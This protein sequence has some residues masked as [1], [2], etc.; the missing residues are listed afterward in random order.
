MAWGAKDAST[1]SVEL[2]TNSTRSLSVRGLTNRD[3][4]RERN[5]SF[6]ALP[7]EPN[8]VVRVISSQTHA[9]M[10]NIENTITPKIEPESPN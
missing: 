1:T 4:K 3:P 7:H 9:V 5:P 10:N 6:I 8:I 2:A